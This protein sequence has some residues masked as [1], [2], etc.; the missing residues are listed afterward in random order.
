MPDKGT[1]L[2]LDLLKKILTNV[3]YEDPATPSYTDPNAAFDHTRRE[4]GTDWPRVAHTMIGAKRID[5]LQHCVETVLADE[6]PGDFIETGVWRGG[7]CIFMRGLLKAHGV[8][9]RQ[10]WVADSFQGMP[11]VPEDGH[12][13]DHQMGLHRANDV[14]GIS[15]ETVRENFR[16]YDLLD[17]Q[18]NFLPGWFRDTLPTA[19]VKELA[20]LRLDGDFY[21]STMDGLNNLYPKLSPGGFVIV[22]DYVHGPCAQAVH[23]Y[24][25][26]FGI[27]E[28]IIDIDGTGVFWRRAA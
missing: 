14:L 16:R 24:R 11:E 28:E 15:E 9:D 2:Y 12:P 5:N 18:V 13:V 27:T 4:N 20:V 6:I 8:T 23:E 7:S 10:I 26:E 3:I 1:E 25:K 21:E 19:P 22:D 17:D